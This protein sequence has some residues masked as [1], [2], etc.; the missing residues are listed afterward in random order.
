MENAR[1]RT[2]AMF[3]FLFVEILLGAQS[4]AITLKNPSFEDVPRHNRT[5]P[6]WVDCGFPGETK[7][8]IHPNGTFGVTKLAKEGSSYLGLVVRE[9]Y[10]W[11][12]VSQQ[13]SGSMQAGSC[14]EFNIYLARS[15]K[16]QTYDYHTNRNINYTH[17][18]KL[19]I[20]GG[21]STCQQD[22]LLAESPLITNKDWQKF[23]C[24]F[25]AKKNYT[26]LTLEA[27]YQEPDV[28]PNHDKLLSP[29][30]FPYNGNILLDNA[31]AITLVNCKDQPFM[32]TLHPPIPEP[33][34]SNE[35]P[36]G[37]SPK[38]PKT[39][40]SDAVST[41]DPTAPNTPSPPIEV[42]HF[43]DTFKLISKGQILQMP[44]IAFKVD[45]AKLDSSS[46]VELDKLSQF[47]A[48]NPGLVIEIGGHT[49]GVCDDPHCN[50]LSLRRAHAVAKYLVEHGADAN[51]LQ[52]KGYGKTKPLSIPK[53]NPVN[54]RVEIK[55]L[56]VK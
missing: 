2:I 47:L 16:Y 37:K 6:G 36:T 4:V 9:N 8:D 18:V 44:S 27:F 29:N 42:A 33:Q 35:G 54:Q 49:N 38:I 1:L 40:P 41:Q 17:E 10:T 13:L 39:P 45:S 46:F 51:R 48:Q 30:T 19:R 32:A 12:R 55:I 34:V 23:H 24:R 28:F 21:F 15:P 3:C 26:H 31:S 43:L 5:P 25:Q 50:N 56:E 53:E 20:F 52:V 11:E 14:Y 22:Q 7:P